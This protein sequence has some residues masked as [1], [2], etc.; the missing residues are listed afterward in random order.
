MLHVDPLR[1]MEL[2]DDLRMRLVLSSFMVSSVTTM[3]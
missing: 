1:S 2:K 3:A